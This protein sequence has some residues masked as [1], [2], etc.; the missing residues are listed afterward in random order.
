[1][2]SHRPQPEPPAES[3]DQSGHD[4]TVST[5]GTARDQLQVRSSKCQIDETRS[6]VCRLAT[7]RSPALVHGR[8]SKSR[9]ETSPHTRSLHHAAHA[10][11]TRGHGTRTAQCR[12]SCHMRTRARGRRPTAPHNLDQRPRRSKR[13]ADLP[14]TDPPLL[15]S[16]LACICPTRKRCRAT[17][18]CTLYAPLCTL[19][20]S[21]PSSSIRLEGAGDV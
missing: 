15:S 10:T 17:V 9:P 14:S 12:V 21:A 4:A 6:P 19:P 11:P 3:R 18:T 8:A 16:H 1:M 7:V 13:T 20:L 5:N 2:H